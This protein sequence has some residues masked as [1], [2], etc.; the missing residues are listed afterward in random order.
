MRVS[1]P[2]SFIWCSSSRSLYSGLMAVLMAPVLDAAKKL[3]MYCGMLGRYMA[4]LSPCLTP[5][6]DR[7][8]ANLSTCS[9]SSL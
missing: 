5:R 8:V 7:A 3:I 4:T 2:E 6:L 1:A 9:F